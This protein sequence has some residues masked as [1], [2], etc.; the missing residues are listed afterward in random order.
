MMPFEKLSLEWFVAIKRAEVDLSKGKLLLIGPNASGKSSIIRALRLAL[1]LLWEGDVVDLRLVNLNADKAVVR[2]ELKGG[3]VELEIE[4]SGR[5]V[6]EVVGEKI[7]RRETGPG[8]LT[9]WDPRDPELVSFLEKIG[10]GGRFAPVVLAVDDSSQEYIDLE[11]DEYGQISFRKSRFANYKPVGVGSELIVERVAERLPL[12]SAD[13]TGIY[14]TRDGVRVKTGGRWMDFDRLASGYKKA[15]AYLFVLES[16]ALFHELYKRPVVITIEEF[17]GRL[18]YDLA[19][20][21]VDYMSRLPVF[22]V[23]ESHTMLAARAALSREWSVYYVAD[24]N[25]YKIE[26]HKDLEKADLFM[27]EYEA[28]ARA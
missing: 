9:L 7:Y 22:I 14:V 1:G 5:V 10:V 16:A 8:S 28:Y 19:V 17:E 12:V 26:S 13:L 2:L 3:A 4:R 6:A 11:E 15:I 27:R 20:D 21:L 24:G 23:V 25:A 18:H